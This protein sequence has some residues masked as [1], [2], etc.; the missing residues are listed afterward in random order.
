MNTVLR[1]EIMNWL[2]ECQWLESEE[3]LNALSDDELERGVNKHYSG[4]IEAFKK[5]LIDS[6][7]EYV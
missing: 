2:F 1:Q 7:G 4:G 5:T 3:E 6:H